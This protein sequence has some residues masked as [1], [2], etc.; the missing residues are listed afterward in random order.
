[1]EA[2]KKFSMSDQED[3]RQPLDVRPRQRKSWIFIKTSYGLD[4]RFQDMVNIAVDMFIVQV[5]SEIEMRI[6]YE[7]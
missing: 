7:Q 3:H 5:E 4:S 6:R 1:M 2:A